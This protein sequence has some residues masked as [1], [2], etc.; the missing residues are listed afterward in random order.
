MTIGGKVFP[1]PTGSAS[2]TIMITNP[3]GAKIE[4]TSEPIQPTGAFFSTF[5]TD[6]PQNQSSLWVAGHYTVTATYNGA[7]GTATFSWNPQTNS[8]TSSTARNN[9]KCKHYQQYGS[10]TTSTITKSSQY[11]D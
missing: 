9:K 3:N 5:T 7:T 11:Y 1:V 10:T 6:Y 8:F 4:S 2:A